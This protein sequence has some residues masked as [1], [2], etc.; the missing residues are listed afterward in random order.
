MLAAA[1]GLD[2]AAAQLQVHGFDQYLPCREVRL[3]ESA[4]ALEGDSFRL[5]TGDIQAAGA[6]RQPQVQGQGPEVRVEG[7]CHGA[8]YG[9]IQ[10][11][12]GGKARR[13]K[14]HQQGGRQ[15]LQMRKGGD[16]PVLPRAP[17]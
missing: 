13:Q 12:R 2:A 5:W 6:N 8:R 17:A 14:R 15:V 11:R 4:A 16:R 7:P 3:N 1:A 10:C 9:C